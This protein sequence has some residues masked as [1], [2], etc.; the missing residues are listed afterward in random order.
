MKAIQII[1]VT[2]LK[3]ISNYGSVGLSSLDES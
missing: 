2:S 3:L 1:K